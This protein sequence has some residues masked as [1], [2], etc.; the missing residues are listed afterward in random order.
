M[1]SVPESLLILNPEV[2]GLSDRA[3]L[4]GK[5]LICWDG[6]E[7]HAIILEKL[8]NL[9]SVGDDVLLRRIGS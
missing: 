9:L 2:G 3:H 7:L 5:V 8:L 4:F 6:F 1:L